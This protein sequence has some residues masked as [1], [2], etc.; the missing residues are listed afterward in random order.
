MGWRRVDGSAKGILFGV[1]K[2]TSS[3]SGRIS[4]GTRTA[5]KRKRRYGGPHA[6]E[7]SAL[8]AVVRLAF[9]T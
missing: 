8:P 5:T 9:E 6:N 3:D 1:A 2:N 7:G 4:T